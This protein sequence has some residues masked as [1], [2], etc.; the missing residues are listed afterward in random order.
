MIRSAAEKIRRL[1]PVGARG[2]PSSGSAAGCSAVP[3]ALRPAF[4]G[5]PR[6]RGHPARPSVLAARVGPDPG[7]GADPNSGG[8]P[9][10]RP[11]DRRWQLRPDAAPP[12]GRGGHRP[13]L[14]GRP[15]PASAVGA[16]GASGGPDSAFSAP[17]SPRSLRRLPVPVPDGG[18]LRR[19]RR[20][21]GRCAGAHRAG[22]RVAAAPPPRT[23]PPR[24]RSGC[25][26]RP[27]R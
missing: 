2:P 16:A 26:R 5:R 15:A 14:A 25:G 20:R 12:R 3:C 13:R 9:S 19:R 8:G 6:D 10:D 23:P 11:L 18:R 4:G 7:R 1:R 22:S 27:A 24:S 21:L 17:R